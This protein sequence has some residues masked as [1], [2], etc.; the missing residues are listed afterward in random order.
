MSDR[1]IKV[2]TDTDQEVA[3]NMLKEYDLLAIPVV[4]KEGILVGIVTV[5]DALDILEK[6]A[7]EDI[8]DAAGFADIATKETDRSRVLTKGNLWRN[9][10][11]RL[12]FLFVALA[13][14]LIA[15]II[16]EGFEEIL[17]AVVVVAFFIP[18][19]LDMGGSA[20]A[21]SATVFARGVVLGHISV[22][23]F[24]MPLLK[25]T[26]IGLTIGA[27][28]GVIAG[29]V[30]VIWQDS[31]LLAV[32]VGLALALTIGLASFLGF[33]TPYVIMK[34]K[35]D[36]AAGSGPIITTIKDITGL[37]IY[38]GLVALLMGSYLYAEPDYK[39]TGMYA[40]VDSI[41]FFL[42]VEEGT[43]LVLR[44]E[45]YETDQIFPE[46]ITVQDVD[47]RV[48]FTETGVIGDIYSNG[49]EE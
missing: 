32:T 33:V 49:L 21:Q 44:K 38:F 18:I 42:D 1:I 28:C 9:W 10:A 2:S 25:E 19:I 11:V 41:H 15:G 17:E 29:S 39:I 14:G 47:F 34:L 8:L 5:D 45:E 16:I 23:R 37:F 24:F 22:K 46:I 27:I 12:P 6:E 31:L 43:A 20:G 30:I 3:A 7:T 36:Q 40:T 4:D 48:T 35:G 26:A 13:G